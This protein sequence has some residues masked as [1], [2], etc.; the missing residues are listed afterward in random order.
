M[1]TKVGYYH[2][3]LMK[4]LKTILINFAKL[5]SFLD[6]QNEIYVGKQVVI[7]TSEDAVE[8]YPVDNTCYT[9]SCD[10]SKKQPSGQY[11]LYHQL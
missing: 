1:F 5:T 11:M 2:S 4:L 10:L 3:G 9:T 8:M 7:V 6:H